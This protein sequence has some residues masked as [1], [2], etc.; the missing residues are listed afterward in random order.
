M[1]DLNDTPNERPY[2]TLEEHKPYVL[3]LAAVIPPLNA[4]ANTPGEALHE[5]RIARDPIG[6]RDPRQDRR[7]VR[8]ARGGRTP[9]A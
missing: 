2:A 9:G 5:I 6:A 7:G 3:V 1:D 8:A 4:I